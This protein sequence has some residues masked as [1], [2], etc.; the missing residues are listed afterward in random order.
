MILKTKHHGNGI[1]NILEER[2]DVMYISL[3]RFTRF[4]YPGTGAADEVGIGAGAG[5]NVNVPFDAIG[6]ND[7]DYLA[8]FDLVL[9]PIIRQFAPDII[10]VSAGFHVRSS[11]V[12][13][14]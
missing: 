1:Q 12:P 13:C 6:M 10:I 14:H 2:D 11:T 4:F 9:A 5:K 3:H 7:A 8:A